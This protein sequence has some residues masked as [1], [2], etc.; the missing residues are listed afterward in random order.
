MKITGEKSLS[1][2]VKLLL[3]TIFILGL[4]VIIGLPVILRWYIENFRVDINNYYPMLMLLYVSGVTA[5]YI[6]FKFVK[7]FKALED[8]KPFIAENVEILKNISIGCLVIAVLYLIGIFIFNSVFVAVI[9]M[10][11]TIAYFAFLILAELFRQ[12]VQYKE[13]N[14]L[15]I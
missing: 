2:I 13:E 6:V 8:N 11:F 14:D 5:L 15:T 3:K 4:G 10:I 1:T 12:A 7:L 9:F